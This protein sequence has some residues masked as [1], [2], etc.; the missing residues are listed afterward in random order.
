MNV[1]DWDVNSQTVKTNVIIGDITED[2]VCVKTTLNV[3][4]VPAHVDAS[5]WK[6]ITTTSATNV[7]N[8]LVI[9][10]VALVDS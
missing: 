10:V 5:V 7:V 6:K 8:A 9:V 4:N 1:V 2:N 3:T